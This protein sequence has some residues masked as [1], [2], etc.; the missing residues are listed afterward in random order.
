MDHAEVT[1]MRERRTD[2][3]RP[4]TPDAPASR[5]ETGSVTDALV[6][7]GSSGPSARDSEPGGAAHAPVRRPG[8]PGATAP[9]D[10]PLLERTLAFADSYV[11]DDGQVSVRRAP[12]SSEYS[13]AR[14]AGHCAVCS[15]AGVLPP[16]GEPLFDVRA[17]A[18]FVSAHT[19]GERD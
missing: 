5:A 2:V 6:R 18:R 3:P 1:D 12:A 13:A 10:E 17:A 7:T 16:A 15:R 19:H 11:S 4:R 9:S 14:F 8:T